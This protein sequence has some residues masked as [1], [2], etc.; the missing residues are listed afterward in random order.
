MY[1]ATTSAYATIQNRTQPT[2]QQ[3]TVSNAYI[4]NFAMFGLLLLGTGTAYVAERASSWRVHIQGRVPFVV[5]KQGVQPNQ[6]Q[7][8]TR[9]PA[10]HLENIKANLMPSVSDLATALGVTRQSVYKWIA[11]TAFPDSANLVRLVELS[12]ISD[13]LKMSGLKNSSSLVKMKIF[14]GYS[15]LELLKLHKNTE[16][17]LSK[18]IAEAQTMEK[19]YLDSKI[20]QSK[21]KADDSWQSDLSVPGSFS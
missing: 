6:S 2:T 9:T 12:S 15:F 11:G 13:R 17:A 14:D 1:S 10:V 20:R 5:E 21:A 18:L 19:A 3:K 4:Q 7:I 8:D 16:D